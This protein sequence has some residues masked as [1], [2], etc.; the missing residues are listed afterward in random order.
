MSDVA[1]LKRK[2]IK[3]GDNDYIGLIPESF[4]SKVKLDNFLLAREEEKKK[5][6]KLSS[7]PYH[8][9]IEPTNVCNLA[10]PLCPTGIGA[11][12]RSK[13]VMSLNQ[14]KEII[15]K[16]HETTL[17]LF[18][19]NWGE[20]TLVHGLP[21]MIEYA[22]SKGIWVHLS[23]N[24]S[25][26]FQSG[27]IEKLVGCGLAMLHVDLDG[28][29]QEVYEKY[30]IKG[31][32]KLVLTNIRRAV[33]I[34]KELKVEYP[35]IEVSMLAMRHNEHQFDA[36]QQLAGNLGVDRYS[37]DR[38]QVNPCTS[39]N[40]LPVNKKYI[41]PTYQDENRNMQCHWPWSGF[42]INWDGNVSACCIVD[43]PK[44]DFGNILLS[45]ITELWNNEYFVLSR[46]EFGDKN[47]NKVKITI[48][49][50]CKNNTHRKNLKRV[51]DSFAITL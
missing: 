18:L 12:T 19:Q 26:N 28:T 6:I 3:Q 23:T 14:F 8:L 7:M 22:S 9:V 41:Y 10:C 1:E 24:F 29:T 46:A 5:E 47:M 21:E 35:T 50:I 51:G 37:I 13:G 42:V 44:A 36:F 11:K 45:D 43:D 49:N 33:N 4:L 30:R 20:S 48:C 31:N 39:T 2:I 32:M 34:K 25:K 40:W 27:F 15:D 17:K 38:I 16:C